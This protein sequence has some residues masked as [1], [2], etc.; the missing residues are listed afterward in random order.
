MTAKRWKEAV[1]VDL[2]A[3]LRRRWRFR[4]QTCQRRHLP[5]AINTAFGLLGPAGCSLTENTPFS[6]FSTGLHRSNQLAAVAEFWFSVD[7]PPYWPNLNSLDFS[8]SSVLRPKGQAT[9]HAN[10]AALRPSVAAE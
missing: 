6:G 3:D 8:T 4:R 9:H 5:R 1:R 7:W 10:L 2:V